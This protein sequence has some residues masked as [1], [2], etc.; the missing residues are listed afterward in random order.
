[1]SLGSSEWGLLEP[2]GTSPDG[3]SGHSAVYDPI[4]DRM[5]VFG[6]HG[7]SNDLWALGWGVAA[8]QQGSPVVGV[9]PPGPPGLASIQVSP[10]PSRTDVTIAFTLAEA[11]EAKISIYDVAG[12]YVKTLADGVQPAG[13]RTFNWDRRTTSGALAQPGLYF[14]ELQSGN[15]RSM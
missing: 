2:S 15:R 14:C 5:L 7:V 6:G 11:G 9:P 8:D 13:R 12:R 1:L 4:G 10:N 3:S